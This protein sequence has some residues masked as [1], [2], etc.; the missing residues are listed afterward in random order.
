[1]LPLLEMF[2]PHFTFA[3][4]FHLVI[5]SQKSFPLKT[6]LWLCSFVAHFMLGQFLS[7]GKKSSKCFLSKRVDK[8]MEIKSRLALAWVQQNQWRTI[9]FAPHG[10]YGTSHGN[11]STAQYN[12][13]ALHSANDAS[14]RNI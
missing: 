6:E 4:Q 9:P 13:P 12:E 3:F 11:F 14:L 1:M 8:G 7:Q 2:T 5:S 10:G